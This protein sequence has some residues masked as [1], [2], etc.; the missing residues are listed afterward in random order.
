MGF[1]DETS[2]FAAKYASAAPERLIPF[3]GV[4]PRFTRD[5][6]GQVEHLLQHAAMLPLLETILGGS[7]RRTPAPC[8]DE[9]VPPAA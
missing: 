6:E 9:A 5:P 4:H 3:G 1:T 2:E 8:A 7:R